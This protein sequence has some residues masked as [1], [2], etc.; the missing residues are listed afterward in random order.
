[1]LEA[2]FFEGHANKGAIYGFAFNA[3]TGEPLAGAKVTAKQGT[4]VTGTDYV[5]ITGK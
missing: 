4:T 2:S 5:P 3:E 1:M